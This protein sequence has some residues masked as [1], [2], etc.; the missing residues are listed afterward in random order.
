MT[1]TINVPTGESSQALANG[2]KVIVWD[3]ASPAST[4]DGH[5][6]DLA[7]LKEFIFAAASDLNVAISAALH[8]DLLKREEFIRNF[9]AGLT[10]T[11]GEVIISTGNTQ[12]FGTDK[13]VGIDIRNAGGT[14][15]AS[16]LMTGRPGDLLFLVAPNSKYLLGEIKG[17]DTP[18]NDSAVRRIWFRQIWQLGL[19]SYDSNAHGAGRVYL[20]Q[21]LVKSTG[22]EIADSAITADTTLLHEN[23][24][25]STV[26]ELVEW[27][28]KHHIGIGK[29]SGYRYVTDS[30]V[31]T[32]GDVAVVSGIAYIHA[33]S[34]AN[35]LVL[36]AR[37]APGRVF[38]FW[39]SDTRYKEMTINSLIGEISNNGKLFF[40]VTDVDDE[41]TALTNNH[42]VSL[43]FVTD[44]RSREEKL[45]W[46]DDMAD[47]TA[48]KYAG[49]NA[50]GKPA[51]LTA[52]SGGGGQD[53]GIKLGGV[54]GAG[55]STFASASDISGK[56][57]ATVLIWQETGNSTRCQVATTSLTGLTSSWQT[58][59][60]LGSGNSVARVQKSTAG[61]RLATGSHATG[62]A[63]A[64]LS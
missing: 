61:L 39:I 19:D 25:F 51:E 24:D 55:N 42:S 13:F 12:T 23:G 27:Y 32:A 20:G 44:I 37:L 52:P 5:F 53:L 36:R 28:A 64:V 38:R 16:R 49:W 4:G 11:H 54:G 58:V 30:T 21:R 41:G 45:S 31:P 17:I 18:I 1:E 22:V 50:S 56:T 15:E 33:L 47:G 60:S 10:G 34:D 35:E 62:C 46:T 6:Q 7:D 14:D 57:S 29:I 59:V 48:N 63:L 2:Q 9:V 3:S 26:G 8:G 40:N 43:Q